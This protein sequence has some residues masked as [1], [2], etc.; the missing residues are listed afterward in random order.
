MVAVKNGMGKKDEEPCACWLLTDRGSSTCGE[1]SGMAQRREQEQA[2]SSWWKMRMEQELSSVFFSFFGLRSP[3]IASG[4]GERLH[5]PRLGMVAP[6]AAL[7]G[8]LFSLQM[9]R[10]AS[11]GS[12]P[13]P[14]FL[15]SFSRLILR[16]CR[17][18]KPALLPMDPH[19]MYN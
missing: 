17:P 18:S 2:I 11:P 5:P 8:S 12:S 3:R 6:L 13:N 9:F 1:D 15:R 4:K 19:C 10:V 7:I 16:C 14:Y